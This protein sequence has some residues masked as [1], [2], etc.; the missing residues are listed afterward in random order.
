[1][2]DDVGPQFA[3]LQAVLFRFSALGI[4]CDGQ[5]FALRA[6]RS[7]SLHVF[8]LVVVQDALNHLWLGAAARATLAFGKVS[9]L[10]NGK[11]GQLRGQVCLIG[12]GANNDPFKTKTIIKSDSRNDEPT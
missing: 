7:L 8:E 3:S 4:F 12:H 5:S 6:L 9:E 1:M 11:A 10:A 2:G